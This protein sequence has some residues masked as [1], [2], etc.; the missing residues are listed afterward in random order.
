MSLESID[1]TIN[2]SDYELLDMFTGIAP[3]ALPKI[4]PSIVEF[5]EHPSFCGKVLYPRQKTLLKVIFLESELLTDYDHDVIGHWLEESQKY[6]DGGDWSV[7]IPLDIYERIEYNRNVGRTHFRE[8]LDIGG[9]RGGK[10]YI[11]GMIGAYLCYEMI[12]LDDPQRY[13]G[14]DPDKD[15]YINIVA[16]S[17][18]QAR[19][20]LFADVASTVLSCKALRPYI[21]KVQEE[22]VRIQTPSNIR[23]IHDLKKRG[24]KVAKDIAG[25]RVTANSSSGSSGRGGA[26]FSQ[27]FDE[28]AHLQES[29][30][31]RSA[32]E[33]YEAYTPSL[34]QI[35]LAALIY[36]PSSPWSKT[37]KFYELYQSAF[38]TN[39]EGKSLYPEM[40]AIQHPSWEAY[41]D[42][43]YDKRIRR[44]VQTYDEQME[45]LK[46]RNPSVFKVEREAKFAETVGAYLDPEM[47]DRMFAP[48]EG[49]TLTHHESG[50]FNRHH[51]FHSDPS[52]SGANMPIVGGHVEQ[53]A[54]GFK[55]VV[56]DHIKVFQPHDFPVDPEAG[57][58]WVDYEA[59]T[60]YIIRLAKRF[61]I[62]M[63][64]FDQWNCLDAQTL[65]PTK[66]GLLTLSEIVGDIPVGTTSYV[67]IEAQSQDSVALIG[68]AHRKGVVPTLRFTTKHGIEIA[69]TPEHRLLVKR[70]KDKPWGLDHDWEWRRADEIREDD[71]LYLRLGSCSPDNE[72]DISHLAPVRNHGASVHLGV[73]R[74]SDRYWVAYGNENGAQKRL[75]IFKDEEEAANMAAEW[76]RDHPTFTSVR[77]YP[78]SLNAS[79]ARVMGLWV[80][81]GWIGHSSCSLGMKDKDVLDV[82]IA[83]LDSVFGNKHSYSDRDDVDGFYGE[84]KMS[85]STVDFFTAIGLNAVMSQ[86][87]SAPW[88]IRRS[89]HHIQAQFI[90]AL[91]EGDGTVVTSD[92]EESV[93]LQTT[94]EILGIQIQQ[95]LHSM[96]I[97]T[98]RWSGQYQYKGEIRKQWRVKIFGRDLITFK[99]KVGF[100]SAR[101]QDALNIAC[102]RIRE[103]GGNVRD[104]KSRGDDWFA[105]R[106][107]S[108]DDGGE[109]DCYDISVPG[110]ESFIANGVVSHNSVFA[111]QKI[112]KAVSSGLTANKGMRVKEVTFSQ[113]ENWKR[114][115]LFKTA[116]YMGWVHAPVVLVDYPGMGAVNLMS[117]ELKFLREK[118]G[119][120]DKQEEGPVQTK[121]VADCFDDQ[122]EV[123]TD[124]GWK[125][126][127]DVDEA[128]RV[129]TM[130]SDGKGEY[131]H[132]THRIAHQ[133][134]GK[135]LTCSS[136]IDFCVTPTHRMLYRGH[137]GRIL[138]SHAKDMP[139]TARIPRTCLP[140]DGAV[141]QFPIG[142]AEYDFEQS[143]SGLPW[144]AW[145]PQG[146][147]SLSDMYSH[148]PMP[149]IVESTG[150][151]RN[152]IYERARHLGLLRG[153]IGD[154][155]NGINPPLPECDMADFARFVGFWLGD[156]KKMTA[157]THGSV[158]VSQ[159]KPEGVAWFSSLV[160]RMGWEHTVD[161]RSK[162]ARR[163]DEWR[164]RFSSQEL[165]SY[166]YALQDGHELSLP[167]DCFTW[168]PDVLWGL[169][170]G[171]MH[172]D[173]CWQSMTF[174]NTS[175]RLVDDFQRLLVHLGMSGN[176]HTRHGERYTH[177]AM[178][179]CHIDKRRTHSRAAK[180]QWV[181]Y[182][183]MVYCLTV[184][185][186]TLLVR[187][188][189]KMM[190]AGNCV[191]QVTV[192][193]LKDQL[194]ELTA[195]EMTTRGVVGGARGSYMMDEPKR[196]IEMVGRRDKNIGRM[197]GVGSPGELYRP[198]RRPLG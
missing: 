86:K 103:R 125:L 152:A 64:S 99:D 116:L 162:G 197:G 109:R 90:S 142:R 139:K 6:E 156:G 46:R 73:G 76:Q 135:M 186:G 157:S 167:H 23:M 121:D 62:S 159:S 164:W 11:G 176:V 147:T 172:S 115:E 194:M 37:G 56:I 180:R 112:R 122:T 4:K 168:S 132:P 188:N 117:E 165:G 189:G 12:R 53:G 138:V 29:E 100:I 55:H 74:H 133:Y 93:Y 183:G 163:H 84:V 181:D 130:D 25:V 195:D 184:P 120:V 52:K 95:M 49:K 48:W 185:N 106:I 13:F 42:W 9:R 85:K 154:R 63:F 190:W 10:G 35:G 33:V 16:T 77:V 54:D 178:H 32:S 96:G 72:V 41:T 40:F 39:D 105:D 166:L 2:E 60:D 19:K 61:N 193:L 38:E 173:G 110:P 22:E 146:D 75:G 14:I 44:A 98:T 71:C 143:I 70:R 104:K 69:C 111:I 15:M 30:S 129:M 151:S 26:A 192:D 97:L 89:P 81:E 92:R 169:Y 141:P 68:T 118:N 82:L 114:C 88:S 58:S 17:A 145:T 137:N 160:D 123:L 1:Y 144:N 170:E 83:D 182:D 171:L 51:R 158:Y 155:H 67:G 136:G 161:V 196:D 7:R 198:T 94:S 134:S 191:M 127:R 91:F 128:D 24:V 150:R 3:K 107:V 5:A 28:F 124:K 119:R 43:Q 179:Y 131:Q 36:V 66:N 101:K 108:I 153:Q 102:D 113:P 18:L 79:L 174:S 20:F 27:M 149:S 59:I 57:V 148:S 50:Q 34:D 21:W 80:A 31:T 65:V 177:G 47:V 45:Q 187:R 140:V 78:S 175:K 126:F 8:I 87:K